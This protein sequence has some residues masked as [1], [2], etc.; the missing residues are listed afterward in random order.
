MEKILWKTLK[1]TKS[2]RQAE[3]ACLCRNLARQRRFVKFLALA[4]RVQKAKQGIGGMPC[5]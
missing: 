5:L 3:A 2:K 1:G 4:C